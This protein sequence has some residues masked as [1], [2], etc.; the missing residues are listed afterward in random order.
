[1]LNNLYATRLV[2]SLFHQENTALNSLDVA[3]A[4]RKNL[5]DIFTRNPIILPDNAPPEIPRVIFQSEDGFAVSVSQSRT[6]FT[7]ESKSETHYD[8]ALGQF[9]SVANK[10]TSAVLSGF[11]IG[12]NRIAF[13]L[14]SRLNL[15]DNGV[16][17]IQDL[18]LNRDKLQDISGAETHWLVYPIIS[19]EEINRWVRVKSVA[20]EQGVSENS[21]DV[22]VDS[23]TKVNL[24]RNYTLEEAVCFIESCCKDLRTNMYG[25]LRFDWGENHEQFR[26]LQ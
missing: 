7:Y 20:N 24:E 26:R 15:S 22:F 23:N 13:I 4:I 17:F 9:V 11:G 18:Y 25:I 3:V 19:G 1:M 21:V 2:L 16:R 14:F 10:L 8:H 6:D 12:V 5:G